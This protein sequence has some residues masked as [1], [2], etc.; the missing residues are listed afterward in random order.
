MAGFYL[1]LVNQNKGKPVI[2]RKIIVFC[3]TEETGIKIYKL[4]TMTL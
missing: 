3:V 2:F 1:S 4:A